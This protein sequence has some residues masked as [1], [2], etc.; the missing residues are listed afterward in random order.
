MKFIRT[1]YFADQYRNFC[2]VIAFKPY[3]K[4]LKKK[5]ENVIERGYYHARSSVCHRCLVLDQASVMLF[6][7]LSFFSL[8]FLLNFFAST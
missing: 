6:F 8:S 4:D 5:I 7:F 3:T 1:R 2:A